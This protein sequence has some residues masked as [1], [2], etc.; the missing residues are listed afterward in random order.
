MRYEPVESIRVTP[1]F[2]LT[3]GWDSPAEC[4]PHIKG[5]VLPP[6]ALG[7]MHDD[8][9]PIVPVAV[10]PDSS[11]DKLMVEV[12]DACFV[13]FGHVTVH[14]PEPLPSSS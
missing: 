11:L 7:F 6:F 3:G 13:A 9:Q 12:H 10:T 14:K 4:P 5:I 1:V 2:A 8:A